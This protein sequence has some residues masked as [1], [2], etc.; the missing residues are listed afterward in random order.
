MAWKIPL[1]DVQLGDE[2]KNAVLAV[3]ESGWLTMGART[4]AFEQAFAEFLGVKHAFAV[5]NCTAALHLACQILDI[6]IGD[7]IILPSLTFVATANSVRYAGAIPVFADILSADDLTV[8]PEDIERRITPKTRA[9][10]VM[11]YAG[12][13]CDMK[14]IRTIA[15]RHH[16]VLI[17][18]AAHAVGASLDG[19]PLGVWGDVACFSFFSNKNMTTGEGGMIVTNNDQYAEKIRLLRSHGMTTLTWDRHRGHAHTYDVVE[20][21]YNYRIDEIRSA[22]GLEQLK[23]VM[24]WNERR[25]ELVRTYHQIFQRQCSEIHIPFQTYR[26]VSSFHIMPVLL[27]EN[28]EKPLFFEQMKENGIQTSFHYPPVHSF[29]V[30]QQARP[31][32]GFNLP[33]TERISRREVTLP[34]Y[35]TMKESDIQYVAEVITH[36][37]SQAPR[38][39]I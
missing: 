4:E 25:K 6:Q 18:D 29:R 35:P 1:A 12:Y 33:M 31:A 3:M 13:A 27:P 8:S 32:N 16:L 21:G 15:D 26:G 22:I 2:E 28:V 36:W 11:H 17:E 20:V 9:I 14:A 39:S 10:M 34:L 19:K 24:A 38:L 37:L 23:K 30:Y 7:E 5:T